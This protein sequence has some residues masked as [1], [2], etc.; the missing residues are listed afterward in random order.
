LNRYQVY[1]LKN[2]RVQMCE[3]DGYHPVQLKLRFVR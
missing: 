3:E 1:N 2:G